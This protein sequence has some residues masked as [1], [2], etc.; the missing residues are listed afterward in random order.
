[1]DGVYYIKKQKNMTS[2]DVCAKIR[3][4]LKEKAVGHTGTLDPNAE[5]LLIVLLGKACKCLPYCEH[6]KKEYIA[7]IKL[8][9][10]TDTGDIWG[11]TIEEKEIPMIT[12]EQF[13]DVL[14][15]FLGPQVQIPPMVSAIK[16]NGKK[17]YEYHREGK[18]VEV[19]PRNI[20]ID[21]IECMSF[22][23]EI[24]IRAV[25]SSGTYIRVLCEDIAAKL[26]T[27]GT[28][29]SLIRTRI[30]NV[31]IDDAITIEECT[32]ENIHDIEDVINPEYKRFEVECVK[33]VMQGKRIKLPCDD[34][35]VMLTHNHKILAAYEKDGNEYRSKR[36]LW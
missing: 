21:E 31:S 1:M 9:I 4:S 20:I 22:A 6:S 11:E 8:G 5:G 27:V 15:S 34:E 3:R 33:E 30:A 32:M 10:K 24:K 36:G 29:S 23:G 7:T 28:M 25:V 12:E 19:K 16:V 13:N 14:K 26:N 18:E 17:L 35:V 2:F